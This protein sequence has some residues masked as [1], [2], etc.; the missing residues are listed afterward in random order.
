[1]LFLR[2][3][4]LSTGTPHVRLIVASCWQLALETVHAVVFS[5][6]CSNPMASTDATLLALSGLGLHFHKVSNL[7]A[8]TDAVRNTDCINTDSVLMSQ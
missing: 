1:M 3:T 8:S 7:M 5:L 6:C 4:L 2:L